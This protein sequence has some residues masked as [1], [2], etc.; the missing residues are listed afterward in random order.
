MAGKTHNVAPVW[1]KVF[2]NVV[3]D[4]PISFL[5]HED[6]GCTQRDCNPKELIEEYKKIFESRISARATKKLPGKIHT[7]R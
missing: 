2:N 4:E 1:K 6:L 3:L 5:D 7:Q